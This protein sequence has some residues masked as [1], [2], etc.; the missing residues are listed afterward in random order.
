MNLE[1]KEKYLKYKKKYKQLKSLHGGSFLKKKPKPEFRASI[2]ECNIMFNSEPTFN[3]KSTFE[4]DM[5][6]GY[7]FFKSPELLEMQ[8]EKHEV[9]E[10][11][12]GFNRYLKIASDKIHHTAQKEKDAQAAKKDKFD[13]C[14]QF[15]IEE[16]YGIIEEIKEKIEKLKSIV[17]DFNLGSYLVDELNLELP[18]N[19]I[20]KYFDSYLDKLFY[21]KI[22][23]MKDPKS[24]EEVST[25]KLNEV[26]D[27][28][29]DKY[30]ELSENGKL[31]YKNIIEKTAGIYRGTKFLHFK[32]PG[33]E[34]IYFPKFKA[35]YVWVAQVVGFDFIMDESQQTQY[36]FSLITKGTVKMYFKWDEVYKRLYGKRSY[37]TYRVKSHYDYDSF[38]YNDLSEP[39]DI[40]K[41][42]II[43]KS[44]DWF[45]NPTLTVNNTELS[46]NEYK[47]LDIESFIAKTDPSNLNNLPDRPYYKER[48]F[49]SNTYTTNL[50]EDR[51]WWWKLKYLCSQEELLKVIQKVKKKN[52]YLVLNEKPDR[53]FDNLEQI[54]TKIKQSQNNYDS[55]EDYEMIYKLL[56]NSSVTTCDKLK[57][58]F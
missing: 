32:T 45:K 26:L 49:F 55:S 47:D 16:F 54:I 53:E 9:K 41:F 27:I 17:L 44:K 15:L 12:S 31:L 1:Y 11:V 42:T 50:T 43:E 46:F 20:R 52:N 34:E 19:S 4:Y 38:K 5:Q 21:S 56:F 25:E 30:K 33:D 2:Y 37:G 10:E 29:I 51:N 3:S 22:E 35:E 14:K 36:D 28:E 18:K 39:S 8:E 58:I 13:K 48:K 23:S 7:N 6:K 24:T 40:P 57:N